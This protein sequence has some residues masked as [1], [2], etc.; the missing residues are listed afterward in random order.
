MD[1]VKHS[2]VSK[3]KAKSESYHV[4]STEAQV[5]L[6]S[7]YAACKEVQLMTFCDPGWALPR[8]STFRYSY[9][10]KKFLYD[11]FEGE[12]TGKKVAP[13]QVVLKMRKQF[14]TS[15]Y[16]TDQQVKSIFSRL[17]T[18]KWKGTLKE[19]V[20]PENGAILEIETTAVEEVD[21]PVAA[22]S[23]EVDI[24]NNLRD[25][26]ESYDGCNGSRS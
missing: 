11:L 12:K 22:E 10:Q 15:E 19:P 21:N 16:V 9:K 13:E 14:S 26:A 18:E 8:R 3:M 2:F 5:T 4:Y 24:A 6:I 20:K 23:D 1:N 7:M 25:A 17:S